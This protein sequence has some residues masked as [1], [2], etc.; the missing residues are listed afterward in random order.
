MVSIFLQIFTKFLEP[1]ANFIKISP[2][3]TKSVKFH[4][5]PA[6]YLAAVLSACPGLPPA[7]A[8]Q[9]AAALRCLPAHRRLPGRRRRLPARRRR[10]PPFPHLRRRPVSPPLARQP[11]PFAACPPAAADSGAA[12]IRRLPGRHRPGAL[13]RLPAREGDERGAREGLAQDVSFFI[14]AEELARG[15]ASFHRFGGTGAFRI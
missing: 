6:D 14:G 1:F 12:V 4:Q 9:G 2:K 13:S 11:P 10:S 8:F 7:A 15:T 3:S 5:I